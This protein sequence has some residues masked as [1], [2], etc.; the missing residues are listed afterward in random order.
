MSVGAISD[1]VLHVRR[2]S[3]LPASAATMCV[4][5]ICFDSP[6]SIVSRFKVI[7]ERPTWGDALTQ[8]CMPFGPVFVELL[9]ISASYPRSFSRCPRWNVRLVMHRRRDSWGVFR[10]IVRPA[11][12]GRAAS[13]SPLIA[14]V[15]SNELRQSCIKASSARCLIES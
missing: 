11:I 6:T 9:E 10:R 12:H 8:P 1:F 3:A 7:T 15:F 4:T 5:L 14:L 13:F 2:K